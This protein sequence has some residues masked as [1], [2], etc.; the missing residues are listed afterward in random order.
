[1][2]P[3]RL[4]RFGPF[5]FDVRAGDLLKH[6]VRIRLPEQAS[7]ILLMLVD[8]PGEV[9]L[10]S[11]IR[12]R[13][14]P[15]DTVVDFDQSINSAVMRLRNTLGESAGAPRYIETLSKRGY[16]F[17]AE[18]QQFGEA[19]PQPDGT[20]E[21]P[22]SRQQSAGMPQTDLEP[23]AREDAE[24]VTA[25]IRW[26]TWSVLWVAA[27]V[28]LA[29]ATGSY[30][31]LGGRSAGPSMRAIPLTT[32]PG[33]QNFPAF[34]P[35]GEKVAFSWV[36]HPRQDGRP[37]VN[38][39]VKSILNGETASV[40]S[41]PTDDRS[42]SWSPDGSQIAFERV[43]TATN[44]SLM[45]APAGGRAERKI[46]DMGVGLAWS[47]DGTEIAYIAPSA[48]AGTGGVL[49]QSLKTGAVRQLTTPQPNRER[50]VAWSPDGK[51]IAFGRVMVGSVRELFIVPSGGGEARQLTFDSQAIGGF[52][53]T[54]DSRELVFQSSRK[55]G[56][57]L[58]R[59]Q[60]AGG[61]PERIPYM[62]SHPDFP[63]VSLRGNRLVYA[64][65]FIDSN[66]WQYGLTGAANAADAVLQ[67]PKCLICSTVEDDSPRFSPD[68]RK[69]VFV[70]WRAGSAELWTANGDGSAPKQ[71][72]SLGRTGSPWWSPDGR[73][74]AFDSRA[75]GSPDVYVI[76]AAGGTPRR[77]TWEP[78]VEIE[79]SWS[80]D[81]RWIYFVS[82]RGGHSHI[83]KAPFAGGPARQVSQGDGGESRESAD[84]KRLY[85]FRRDHDDGLWSMPVEGG[86]EEVIPELSG[87][88]RTRAWTVREEGIYFYQ[89]TEAKPKIQFFDFAT[90]RVTTLLTPERPVSSSR[91]LEIS[92]DGRSL[93]YT[94]VDR[95]SDGLMMIENFR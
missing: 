84:G 60:A 12:Q 36:G 62:A 33:E 54:P 66:I 20:V 55:S 30:L 81:G 38:I 85:Y 72:T 59:I 27:V 23:L 47:P 91:G 50:L 2:L 58:W 76:A 52:A 32:L 8:R 3:G 80:H 10:R 5:E 88:A 31:H 61:T 46:A 39:Y 87:V 71:L 1:M 65:S 93:L 40:T 42:P 48:P 94:Q 73:W 44:I 51:Q 13:L 17:T 43:V 21:A 82:D 56:S 29:V 92:P 28:A 64:D 86:L 35:D 18:V 90:R 67:Q 19:P 4:L 74:I 15:D 69:I 24:P 68:G 75:E 26:R 25:P 89:D 22:E 78:S 14:W 79:P 11:E 95:R 83:W 16:R 6:G 41:G 45:I 34:S 57:S 70:S 77:L 63:S 53:W 7:Q 9:V 49:V 37:A